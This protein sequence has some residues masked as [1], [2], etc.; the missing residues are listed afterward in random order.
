MASSPLNDVQHANFIILNGAVIVPTYHQPES[1]AQALHTVRQ[2]F[3]HHE[4]IGSDSGDIHQKRS[5]LTQLNAHLF[6]PDLIITLHAF[7][8]ND[9]VWDDRSPEIEFRR[10]G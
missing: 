9:A 8:W 10:I 1:D 7:A 3:P 4:V 2:A 6:T 5:T